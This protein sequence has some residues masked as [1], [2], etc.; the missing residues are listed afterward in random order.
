MATASHRPKLL[1]LESVAAGYLG[2][3]VVRDVC[4]GVGAGEVV[5]LLGSNGA[6]KTTTLSTIAGF[7]QP[8]AGTVRFDGAATNGTPAH[9]IARLGLSFVP[10]NR[11]LFFGLTVREHL[12][13]AG[14]GRDRLDQDEVLELLPE[15]EKCL[16]RKAGL[17]SGGEQQMLSLARALMTRPKLLLID[18]MSLGLA[19][20]LVGRM[21]GVLRD[22]AERFG[23]AVLVVE[24]HVTSALEVA[25]RAYVMSRGRLVLDGQAAELRQNPQLLRSSYLG[26]REVP[27]EGERSHAF[28]AKN[29]RPAKEE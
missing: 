19:P 18:E 6:G 7:V 20:L 12:L 8:M 16:G 21:M 28:T 25:D 13:L 2:T 15:L 4:L 1:E 29:Q 10:E 17:L 27:L 22:I 24:Q 11:G 3:P 23:T 26:E 5:A 14:R 9:R